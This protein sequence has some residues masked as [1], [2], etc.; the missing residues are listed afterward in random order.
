MMRGLHLLLKNIFI[1]FLL[2]F[3]YNLLD[4]LLLFNLKYLNIYNKIIICVDR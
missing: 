3:M 2:F 1:K 4:K